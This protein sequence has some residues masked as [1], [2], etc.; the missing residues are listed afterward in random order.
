MQANKLGIL[1]GGQLAQMLAQAAKQINIDVICFES[2]QVQNPCAAEIAPVIPVD[3]SDLASMRQLICDKNNAIT[4]LTI[5]T[6][7]IPVNLAKSLA[8]SLAFYPSI[9]ALEL[10]QDRLFEKKLFSELNIPTPSYFNITC[11][12]DLISALKQIQHHAVLKTRTMGYDGKGQQV[13]KWQD[14]LQNTLAVATQAYES[15]AGSLPLILERFVDF[16]YEVSLI[17][18]RDKLGNIQYYPLTKNTHESGIL[19]LSEAP[20]NSPETDILRQQAQ[21]HAQKILTK[22]DYVGVLAIE[23][24]VKDKVLIA[25]E[26]A[27]RVHNSG[28]WTIEGAKT[29]QF[30]NHVRAVCGLPLGSTEAIGFSVMQNI[31]SALPTEDQI[32][33]IHTLP[34]IYLHLYNKEP[35]PNRK[36]GHMTIWAATQHKLQDL[37]KQTHVT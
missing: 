29:S 18:V 15:L 34:G 8:E 26:M 11:L 7:N 30:E 35:R 1:G 6:E 37:I 36:L 19:I 22:L 20:F 13:V 3:F 31:I 27:P 28:H 21:T 14:N 10:S 5:E 9:K 12:S 16:D 2:K 32:N 33:K 4:A 25:N 24:F 23:F 17:S